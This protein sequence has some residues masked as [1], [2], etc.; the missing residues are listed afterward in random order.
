MLCVCRYLENQVSYLLVINTSQQDMVAN[1][2]DQASFQ[3]P[4]TAIVVLTSASNSLHHIPSGSVSL[5]KV[6]ELCYNILEMYVTSASTEC[7][8]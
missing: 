6:F 7:P 1:L 4:D 3:L 8:H 2:H 5:I